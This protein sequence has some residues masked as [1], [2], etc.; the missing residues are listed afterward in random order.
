MEK[1][2]SGGGEEQEEEGEEEEGEEWRKGSGAGRGEEGRRRGRRMG[3]FHTDMGMADYG[4][5]CDWRCP[6]M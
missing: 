5:I 2:R 4:Y 6:Y 3:A 1:G